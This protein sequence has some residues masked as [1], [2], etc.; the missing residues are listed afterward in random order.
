MELVIFILY[1]APVVKYLVNHQPTLCQKL[2]DIF[3]FDMHYDIFLAKTDGGLGFGCP[4][5]IKGSNS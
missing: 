3:F 4:V 5:W 1:F 2:N